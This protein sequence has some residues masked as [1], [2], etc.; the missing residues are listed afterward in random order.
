MIALFVLAACTGA[1]TPVVVVPTLAALPSETPADAALNAAPSPTSTDTPAPPATATIPATE[2]AT[3]TPSDTPP[4]TDTDIPP[5]TATATLT[6]SATASATPTPTVTWTYT[7]SLTITNTITPLPSPT[8]TPSQELSELGLLALLSERATIL[9]PERLYN[10]PTLTA[11]AYAAQTLI[12]GGVALTPA[13]AGG[14]PGSGTPAQATLPPASVNCTVPPP[15]ALAADPTVVQSLGCPVGGI[16]STLTAVQSF[17]HGSMVYVQGSP[18]SIYVLTIDGRFRRFDDTWVSGSDPETGGE[19]PP[20]GLIEPKRGFGKVWRNNLDVRG[21][22]GWG[23]TEEQGATTSVQLFERGRAI[24][25]PQRG[26]TYLLIDDPG[27]AT[28]TWRALPGGF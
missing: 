11:V 9:P 22:L 28:G 8:F 4:P 3:A 16:V 15:A 26:E 7:P 24:F 17:E 19:T 1:P 14:T 25:M 18:G 6:A 23:V 20:L 12:A 21:S 5:A 10:P 13:P 27:G 2:T